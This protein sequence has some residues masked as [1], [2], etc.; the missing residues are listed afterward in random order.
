MKDATL[1][2]GNQV[3][4]LIL[5]KQT[6][7]E[8]LQ[9][10]LESGLL[11]D[12]LDAN[13]EGGIDR[14]AFRRLIGL[15]PNSYPVQVNYDLSV[16]AA[17]R[18]GKYDWKNENITSANFPPTRQGTMDLDII[19]VHYGRDMQDEEI[20]KDLE[21]QGLRD[22][23]LPELLALGA[24]YPDLQRQFPIIARGSV[25]LFPSDGDRGVPYLRKDGGGR[26]LNLGWLGG[27]WGSDYRF[28]AVRK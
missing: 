25:W 28:A 26:G 7:S 14:N 23:E 13:L 9:K 1:A 19:L 20:D 21:R 5:Q 6:P 8:Q 16:E 27:R 17:I 12:L 22:A 10:L 15:I 11:S 3:T 4:N 18:A 2:Q 24:K